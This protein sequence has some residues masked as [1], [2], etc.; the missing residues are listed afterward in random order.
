MP[1]Y[2]GS[3]TR[4]ACNTPYVEGRPLP[5]SRVDGAERVD[6]WRTE[7]SF[8]LVVSGSE[9]REVFRFSYREVADSISGGNAS[10]TDDQLVVAFFEMSLLEAFYFPARTQHDLGAIAAWVILN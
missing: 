5:L 4:A 7:D 1:P 6:L 10:L 9:T 2:A 8:S 3:L